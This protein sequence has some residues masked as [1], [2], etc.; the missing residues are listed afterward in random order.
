[1]KKIRSHHLAPY[2]ITVLLMS[3]IYLLG[4]LPYYKEEPAQTAFTQDSLPQSPTPVPEQ[5]DKLTELTLYV[6][7]S[8]ITPGESAQT[9]IDKFGVPGRIDR[10]EYG[11]DYYI[12]NNDYSRMALIAVQEDIVIG[13]YTDSSD[14]NYQGIHY[15]DSLE[16]VNQALKK[17]FQLSEVITYIK[18]TNTIHIFMDTLETK[19]VTGIY[20]LPSDVT[21]GKYSTEI[22]R[23]IESLLYDLTNAVRA[24]NKLGPLSWSS[25]ASSAAR[26]HSASMSAGNYLSHTDPERRS[27]GGRLIAE[28]IG[29]EKCGE[30]I[31]AG[32][33]DA[34]L[35]IHHLYNSKTQRK[36]L[37]SKT[38]RY[39]GDGFSYHKDSQYKTY[40]TQ[41]FYR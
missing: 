13:Y 28:G 35:A 8:S 4:L 30:N 21:P 12:Y 29:Y 27:P 9:V 23:G 24:H 33:D 38:Y 14:L 15:G 11:F 25:S 3:F 36:N 20:V 1:M 7:D 41:N 17:Q 5:S 19:T 39:T 34:I 31:I 16:Q 26:K 6:R 22:I 37:L 32:Y 10:T 2:L 40:I 18:G